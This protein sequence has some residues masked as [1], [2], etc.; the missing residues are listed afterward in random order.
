MAT[1]PTVLASS[2]AAQG[3]VAAVADGTASAATAA[4]PTAETA[5]TAWRPRRSALVVVLM[6]NSL[7]FA[8]V[9]DAFANALQSDGWAPRPETASAQS[10]ISASAPANPA[11]ERAGEQQEARSIA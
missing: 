5:N 11:N 7:R 10:A 3:S 1:E 9:F 6:D 8:N 2:L 4:P